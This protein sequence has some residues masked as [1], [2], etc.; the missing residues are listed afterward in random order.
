MTIEYL[1]NE[2]KALAEN[3]GDTEIQ[4]MEADEILT[5]IL[6]KLGHSDVVEDYEKIRK[7]YA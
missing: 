4:H 1:K 2:M 6:V 3:P 7:W 5:Q